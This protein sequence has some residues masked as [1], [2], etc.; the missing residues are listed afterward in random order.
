MDANI[1]KLEEKLAFMQLD[2]QQMSDEIF[3]QQRE[4]TKL[5]SKIDRLED[6]VKSL[7][8]NHGILSPDDDIPPPH[9]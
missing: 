9:Y 8:Q 3:A 6:K 1:K 7:D 2:L 4:I 5:K